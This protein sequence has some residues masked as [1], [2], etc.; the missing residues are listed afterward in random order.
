MEA[1]V[2]TEAE[3]LPCHNQRVLHELHFLRRN[4]IEN[5]EASPHNYSDIS[6]DL[7]ATPAKS[8]ETLEI[9]ETIARIET[10]DIH[11]ELGN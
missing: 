10:D 6:N 11:L 4:Q 5:S 1:I 2:T 7:N 3:Q 9:H 8:L